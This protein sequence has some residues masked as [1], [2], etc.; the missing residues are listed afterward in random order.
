MLEQLA[1]LRIA[2]LREQIDYHSKRYYDEDAP[3]IEDDEFDALT[4]ELRELEE[5]YPH[6]ITPDSYT[7]RVHG[8]V[9]HLFEPVTHEVPLGSLQDVFSFDELYSFDDRMKK[10]GDNIKYVVE[11][12]IDGLSVSLL[13]ELL[14]TL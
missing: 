4:R 12:K 13:Y 2:E 1:A 3:E 14:I 8:K 10:F 7:Q 6:L 9:S 11:T 5:Q